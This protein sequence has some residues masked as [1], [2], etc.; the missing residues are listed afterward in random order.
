MVK[1]A[2]TE[3]PLQA[4]IFV[5]FMVALKKATAAAAPAP[6]LKPIQSAPRATAVKQSARVNKTAQQPQ[7]LQK[8]N[9]AQAPVSNP[10]QAAKKAPGS[11]AIVQAKKKPV[12]VRVRKPI[13]PEMRCREISKTTGEQ[14]KLQ[15][16]REGQTKCPRHGGLTKKG[17]VMKEPRQSIPWVAIY[18]NSM[19]YM[20]N[21]HNACDCTP[22]E[23]CVFI[24]LF[25][26]LQKLSLEV[27]NR[28]GK[29]SYPAQGAL[30]KW[31]EHKPDN[32]SDSYI[33]RKL[34]SILKEENIS[35]LRE[36]LEQHRQHL[37]YEAQAVENGDNNDD[38]DGHENE[39]R[40]EENKDVEE[41]Q[42]QEDSP[43]ASSNNNIPSDDE[44]SRSNSEPEDE[45]DAEDH[46][47]HSH[48]K[49]QKNNNSSS[50][51]HSDGSL[52][53]LQPQTKLVALDNK[54]D[55][56]HV[57]VTPMSQAF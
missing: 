1:L 37:E 16:S 43:E 41:Q 33:L 4:K 30:K 8:S 11:V 3:F 24:Q 45:Q 2:E 22:Q 5:L 20:L 27:S 52:E 26:W 12:V 36:L 28:N 19:H 35:W 31:L 9:A 34:G 51:S 49:R 48:L 29:S 39:N 15:V 53:E 44:G 56:Q 55:D 40:N 21:Q 46:N 50:A 54:D 6:S 32:M 14:C 13:P 18:A 38:E 7:V 17:T 57:Q 10:P 23:P 42:E 47:N 25:K